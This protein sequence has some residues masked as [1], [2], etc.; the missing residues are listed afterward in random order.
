MIPVT[1]EF[2]AVLTRAQI[3]TLPRPASG[4]WWLAKKNPSGLKFK[5]IPRIS[6]VEK[7][8]VTAILPRGDYVLGCGSFRHHFKVT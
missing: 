7:L 8:C 2:S 1:L 4:N 6:G 5:K 3:N